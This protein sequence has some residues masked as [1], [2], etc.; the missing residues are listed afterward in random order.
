[1][2]AATPTAMRLNPADFEGARF[3]AKNF[4]WNQNIISKAALRLLAC[5]GFLRVHPLC[6]WWPDNPGQCR[7]PQGRPQRRLRCS[8]GTRRAGPS[9]LDGQG[10]EMELGSAAAGRYAPI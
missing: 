9:D 5:R 6:A 3:I 7:A 8:C 2:I 4:T 10:A 1:M